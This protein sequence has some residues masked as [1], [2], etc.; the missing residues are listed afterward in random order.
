MSQ[1]QQ[2]IGCYLII[3]YWEVELKRALAERGGACLELHRATWE[4]LGKGGADF[5]FQSIVVQS[6][7]L[8]S[9]FFISMSQ[10]LGWSEVTFVVG[11][12]GCDGPGA[13]WA[14]V[15][16]ACV[17]L[18]AHRA[19]FLLQWQLSGLWLSGA[20]WWRRPLND[21]VENPTCIQDSRKDW[22]CFLF[23]LSYVHNDSPSLKHI[24]I[25]YPCK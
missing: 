22:V 12:K 7:R 16:M 10:F 11:A 25:Q 20:H 4:P 3:L 1:V 6:K 9:L 8:T 14:F 13:P 2:A 21:E 19:G 5:L 18:L 23:S 24:F 17:G 15:T